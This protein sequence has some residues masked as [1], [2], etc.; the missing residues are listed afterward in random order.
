MEYPIAHQSLEPSPSSERRYRRVP[1]PEAAV[2]YERFERFLMSTGAGLRDFHDFVSHYGNVSFRDVS[3]TGNRLE[4]SDRPV[5]ITKGVQIADGAPEEHTPTPD[6]I[7]A[8]R[9]TII[10]SLGGSAEVNALLSYSERALARILHEA[11]YVVALE[12]G[13]IGARAFVARVAREIG[14]RLS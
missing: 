13:A 14:V 12:N 5:V 2:G 8:Y 10:D 9:I 6:F 1:S 7:N 3:V 4:R 11:A